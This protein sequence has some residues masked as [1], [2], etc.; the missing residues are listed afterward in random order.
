MILR[1]CFA[2]AV[3]AVAVMAPQAAPAQLAPQNSTRN[4]EP[5]DVF[6]D[7]VEVV[8]K[9]VTLTG[10]ARAVQGEAIL[11]ADVIV[12]TLDD[13]QKPKTINCKSNV[14]YS[15]GKE[16]VAGDTAL[17]DDAARTITFTGDVLVTQGE[18]VITGEVLVYW[19]DTGRINLTPAAGKRIHGY[20]KNKPK[21]D[22]A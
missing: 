20:F 14:R 13:N 1:S 18:N 16:S 12:A 22:G 17:Y 4:D 19:I 7:K 2:A 15:N 10:K 21:A 6:G 3:A 8:D 9:V 11:T 5:V